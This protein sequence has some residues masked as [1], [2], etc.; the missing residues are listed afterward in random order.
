MKNKKKQ[1]K[2]SKVLKKILNNIPITHKEWLDGYW[3]WRKKNDE[4]RSAR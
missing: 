4:S 3:K 2:V 1:A